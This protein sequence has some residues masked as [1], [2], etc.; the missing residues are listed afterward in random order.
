M[1]KRP[2]GLI[3]HFWDTIDALGGTIGITLIAVGILAFF[4]IVDFVITT[5]RKKREAKKKK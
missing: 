4:L 1:T 2:T 3:P 5:S